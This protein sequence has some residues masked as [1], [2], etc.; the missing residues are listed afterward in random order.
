MCWANAYTE[1][2]NYILKFLKINGIS[3][4]LEEVLNWT[5]RAL[6]MSREQ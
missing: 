5:V 4:S 1:F 2:F 6:R 3:V